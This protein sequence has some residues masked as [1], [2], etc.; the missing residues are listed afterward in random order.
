MNGTAWTTTQRERLRAMWRA[1]P[2]DEILDWLK[3]HTPGAIAKKAAELGLRRLRGHYGLDNRVRSKIPFIGAL[4][5]ERVRQG[6]T[7]RQLCEKM[8]Y[9]PVMLARW[10]RGEQRPSLLKLVDWCDALGVELIVRRKD[11]S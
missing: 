11:A 1:A 6:L 5:D 9:H 7:R 4:F 2:M 8:G 10:E 3:P